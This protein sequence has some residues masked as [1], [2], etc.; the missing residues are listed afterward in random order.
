VA[1]EIHKSALHQK[2]FPKGRSS[3]KF[4]FNSTSNNEKNYVNLLGRCPIFIDGDSVF[5]PWLNHVWA[6]R[7]S[8]CMIL[9]STP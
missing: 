9:V 6:A 4:G 1:K 7:G 5:T 8:I 3:G 2:Q